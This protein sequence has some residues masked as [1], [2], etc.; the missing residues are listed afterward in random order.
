M[1]L[2]ILTPTEWKPAMRMNDVFGA[3][4]NRFEFPDAA[5]ALNPDIA[6]LYTEDRKQHDKN[7]E[8]AIKKMKK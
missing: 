1:C 8:E 4:L 6:K 7:V 2:P 5:H 3:I